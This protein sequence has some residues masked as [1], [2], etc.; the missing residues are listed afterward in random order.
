MEEKKNWGGK[1]EGAGRPKSDV[2]TK[3]ISIK[4]ETELVKSLPSD[5]NRS[6][7]VNEAVREKMKKDGYLK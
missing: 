7:Y 1:R 4:M 2:E 5:I 6:R 3:I